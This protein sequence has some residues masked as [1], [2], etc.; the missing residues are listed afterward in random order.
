MASGP[1]PSPVAS[2]SAA[3]PPGVLS[4][5]SSYLAAPGPKFLVVSG[6]VGSGKSTFLRSLLTTLDGP[7]LYLAYQ[8]SSPGGSANPDGA[9]APVQMLL[10]DPQ[11]AG[12]DDRPLPAGGTGSPPLAFSPQE[13]RMNTGIAGPLADAV[14]AMST[15]GRGSII[16]D[17]WDRGS[18]AFFRSMAPRPGSV[19]TFLAPPSDLAALQ[20]G[21]LGTTTH[22][23]LG[24][25]P[26]LGAPLY[27]LADALVELKA[28]EHP[29]GRLRLCAVT[30][31]RGGSP[32]PPPSLYTLDGER[33]LSLP[34][35]P[36]GFRPPMGPPEPDPDPAEDSLW[37]GS[38]PLAAT[39]GRLRYGGMTA[40]TLT[41]DCPDTLPVALAGPVVAHALRAGGH[42]VWIPAPSVRPTR[43]LGLLAPLVPADWIRERLRILSATG[44]EPGLGEFKGVIVP[45]PR[46]A[47]E[48]QV[49]RPSGT[50]VAGP[51]FPEV[52][53][54]LRARA[55]STP[56]LYVVSLEGLRATTATAGI[57]ID[58]STLAAVAGFYA[59]VPRFH[60][61]SYGGTGDPAAPQLMPVA[62]TLVH[63]EVL[64]GRPVMFAGRPKY[65]PMVFDWTGD[66]GRF[67]LL[68]IS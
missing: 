49:A 66:H 58:D 24:V 25:T 30:K 37:P 3:T 42:V 13:R 62:D 44:D 20:A 60:L 29:R 45:L 14:A 8:T 34:P 56:A 2:P 15:R 9:S 68:P 48:S 39:L 61:F 53:R 51:L 26:E 57:R 67:A 7:K 33:F 46:A 1:S 31:V 59:R 38:A 54:F 21:I 64:H 18:E 32:P 4:Y 10:A 28:E 5:L 23:V 6:P 63:L 35:L 55:E 65:S 47:A 43:L 22:L 12:A 11:F 50:A 19:R 36:S 27:T 17:S 41:P 40:F 52:Y 16:V